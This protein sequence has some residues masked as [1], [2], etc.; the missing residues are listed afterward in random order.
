MAL[1]ELKA[2]A[3][4]ALVVFLGNFGPE[5]PETLLAKEFAGPSMFA[6]AAEENIPVL[7][8]RRGDAYC[9]MLNASY[10]LKLRGLTSYIPEYPV[11][12]ACAVA[13]MI[14]DFLPVA[15]AIIGVKNLKIISFGPRPF[16]FLACNAPI[17][18]MYKLGVTVQENSEMDLLIAFEKHA[19]DRA[20]RKSPWTWLRNWAPATRCRRCFRSWRSLR[21]RSWIGRRTTW[22]LRSLWRSP[23]SAGRRLRPSLASCPAM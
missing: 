3:V 1:D 16:D 22:A 11:G 20:F 2:S 12:D 17:A 18:P 21:S 4:N 7:S 23:T 14:A 9:G 10:N 19:G 6:A 5:G 13:K 15:R 8:G